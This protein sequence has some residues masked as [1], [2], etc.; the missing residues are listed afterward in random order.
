MMRAP[1]LDTDPS[2]APYDASQMSHQG[3][4]AG[5][6]HALAI[7]HVAL[8]RAGENPLAVSRPGPAEA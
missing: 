1:H 4:P 3:S 7:R 5:E 2:P 8:A 6:V